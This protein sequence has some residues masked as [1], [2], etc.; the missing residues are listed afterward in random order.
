[1]KTVAEA[2]KDSETSEESDLDPGNAEELEE[3]AFKYHNK[4][5]PPFKQSPPCSPHGMVVGA[6]DF[7]K[8][9]HQQN[10]QLCMQIQL[11]K[12]NQAL[13]NEFYDLHK[14]NAA[15]KEPEQKGVI[16]TAKNRHQNRLV[17]PVAETSATWHS[18]LSSSWIQ[19]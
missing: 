6:V 10:Q 3:E 18:I 8:E 5:C 17:F 7:N 4:D 13:L 16:Q 12:E 1:M 19:F 11:E 2:I 9:L 14:G 15:S